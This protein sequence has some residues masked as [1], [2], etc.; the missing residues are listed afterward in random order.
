MDPNGAWSLLVSDVS[1][2]AEGTLVN[3]GLQISPVPEPASALLL[4]LGFAL[5]ACRPQTRH[6]GRV[7]E[8]KPVATLSPLPGAAK[9]CAELA[10][11]WP[12]LEKLSPDEANAFADD[13]ERARANPP[14]PGLPWGTM[15]PRST[16]RS[17]SVLPA[18]AW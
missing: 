13:L 10:E 6:G 2:G 15:S 9:S 1:S 8:G 12:S 18:C 14:P 5:L 3:W 17:F 4:G 7:R 16:P 11:R